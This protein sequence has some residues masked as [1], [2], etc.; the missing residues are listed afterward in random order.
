MKAGTFDDA[1]IGA[2][3]VGL[4]HAYHLA[5]RGRRVVVL[6][7]HDRARGASVR[8][9]G[10]LWPIGQPAGPLRT[11]AL[12]SRDIWLDVLSASGLWHDL[13]GSLHIAYADEEAE[14]LIEFADRAAATD[15]PCELV[16]PEKAC[17]LSPWLRRKGLRLALWSDREICVDPRR[18]IAAL[19]DWLHRSL[20]VRFEFGAEIAQCD[21]PRVSAGVRTWEADRIW[22]CAGDE[23]RRLF[24]EALGALNLV[25]CK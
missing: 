15:F 18:T 6:E 13:S 14:V 5:S 3:I 10:M 1:V 11:L 17:V 25:P 4:A 2:G 22:L 8:N 24:P 23:L 21:G 20:G 7:R 19:P 16:D 9:F 12:R